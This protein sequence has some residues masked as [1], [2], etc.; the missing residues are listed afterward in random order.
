[1]YSLSRRIKGESKQSLIQ[2]ILLILGSR[3]MLIPVS[4]ASLKLR[5]E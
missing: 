4:I 1:L 2:K 3:T 5:K